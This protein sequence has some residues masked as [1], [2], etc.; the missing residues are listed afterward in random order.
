VLS[1]HGMTIAPQ[2]YYRWL[3][4]PIR[5]AEL[6]AAYLVNTIVDIYRAE[7]MRVRS[8]EDVAHGPSR[9]AGLGLAARRPSK[10]M[11]KA[12]RGGIPAD[13]SASAALYY[14]PGFS[15][16]DQLSLRVM[17]WRQAW[18]H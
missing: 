14:S 13:H 3:A 5:S 8:A 17:S 16:R 12:L 1:E 10:V 2:T 9:R 18:L 7:Q 4:C 6:E 11:S 15:Q